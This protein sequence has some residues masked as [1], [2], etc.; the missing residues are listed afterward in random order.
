MPR[1]LTQFL[2]R[3]P[4][5][6]LRGLA[7]GAWWSVYPHSSYWRLGGND[8]D[9]E[10]V[11]RR[12][13]CRPGLVCW[14]IGAHHGI[15]SVG[16]ARAVGP[17][18]RVEAFEPDPVSLGR[19]RWHRR[20]NRLDNLR[21]HAVAASDRNGSARLY[22]YDGFGS[23]TSHLPYPG[24]SLDGVA[25]SDIETARLD[26]W[27]DGGRLSPPAFVKIDVEGHALPALAGMRKTLSAALPVVL[28]AVHT[29]E[30]LDGGR[31]FFS[32]LGYT[33]HPVS[34]HAAARL[35]KDCFGELV[36]LPPSRPAR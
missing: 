17:G 15:Y 4:V 27:V 3:L 19:L 22:Q 18:G 8:P 24:E 12:H 7:C 36:C 11:L 25:S 35:E 30:E 5:P 31:E 1:A 2:G 34:S 10:A 26:D 13:A 6:V 32:G 29:R 23:T 33:L 9:I 28:L 16:L 20:L 21:V 14:D